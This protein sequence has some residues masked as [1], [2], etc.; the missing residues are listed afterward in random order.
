MNV[1]VTPRDAMF[2]LING[3]VPGCLVFCG[4]TQRFEDKFILFG[5][6]FTSVQ[7]GVRS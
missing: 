6:D 1:A 3:S 7:V 4:R 5:A 2:C